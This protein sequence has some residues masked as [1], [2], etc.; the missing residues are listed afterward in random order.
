M[1]DF[2]N[3]TR[4]TVITMDVRQ[5]ERFRV[6]RDK[7]IDINRMVRQEMTN[8]KFTRDCFDVL[9]AANKHAIDLIKMKISVIYLREN[10]ITNPIFSLVVVVVVEDF[11]LASDLTSRTHLATGKNSSERN[12]HKGQSDG[13]CTLHPS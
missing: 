3:L 8:E 10:D 6:N 4:T 2:Y 9:F 11:H 12:Q 1:F 5:T 7:L 13:I